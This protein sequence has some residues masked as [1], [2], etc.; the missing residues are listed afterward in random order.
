MMWWALWWR[1]WPNYTKWRALQTVLVV[2]LL[3]LWRF[4]DAVAFKI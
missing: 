2:P 4:N 1:C 3:A